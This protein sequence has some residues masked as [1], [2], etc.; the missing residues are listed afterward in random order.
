[1]SPRW[2]SFWFFVLAIAFV[3]LIDRI[4]IHARMPHT[5]VSAAQ[6]AKKAVKKAP[7]S[8]TSA[9]MALTQ[10]VPL[11]PKGDLFVRK[12]KKPKAKMKVKTKPKAKRP[13]KVAAAK[14]RKPSPLPTPNRDGD[15]PI[16][17]VGYDEIGFSPY[18]DAIER[19]GRFF[20]LL[21]TEKGPRLGP[22]VSLNNGVLS[23]HKSD[24]SMLAADRPHLVSDPM[25][26]ERLAAIELPQGALDDSVVLMFTKPFDALLWDTISESLSKHGFSLK[27]VRLISGA[28]INGN[29][30]VFLRL[31]K[32]FTKNRKWKVPLNR[33]MRVSLL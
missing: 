13:R 4:S 2:R 22:E 29:R 18:L 7:P 28:Y 5:Q 26:Q 1:M 12:T 6:A 33:R 8:S 23:T 30:G 25:I 10:L 19:V 27:H 3:I 32:A 17:E 20:V 11:Y 31:D 24:L 9:P 21:K 16:L 15:R 14:K